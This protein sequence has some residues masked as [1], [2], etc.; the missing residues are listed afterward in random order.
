M[1]KYTL[2]KLTKLLIYLRAN[3]KYVF[4]VLKIVRLELFNGKI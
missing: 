1:E 2:L 3:N 4:Q